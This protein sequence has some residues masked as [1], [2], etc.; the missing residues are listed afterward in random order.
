MTLWLIASGMFF[1]RCDNGRLE[2]RANSNDV[3]PV[4]K[5]SNYVLIFKDNSGN[6]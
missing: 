4:E 3:C 6:E 5:K 1:S 2:G